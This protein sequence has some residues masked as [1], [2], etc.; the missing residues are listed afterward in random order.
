MQNDECR[1]MNERQQRRNAEFNSAFCIHHSAFRKRYPAWIRT[2]TKRAKI[3]CATVTLRA[4]AGRPKQ[5]AYLC[6]KGEG[7]AQCRCGRGSSRGSSAGDVCPFA[8]FRAVAVATD[9]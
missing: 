5:T 3:S 6:P 8:S 1:M 2:R 4:S 9:G 7:D